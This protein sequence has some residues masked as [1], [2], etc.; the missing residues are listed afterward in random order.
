VLLTARLRALL[1]FGDIKA[2]VGTKSRESGRILPY[3]NVEK[4]TELRVFDPRRN[5]A[6][7]V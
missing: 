6:G 7:G 1:E 4:T 3:A 5:V 2:S